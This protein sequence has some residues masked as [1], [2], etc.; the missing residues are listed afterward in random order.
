MV[1]IKP[2]ETDPIIP[3]SLSKPAAQLAFIPP[4]GPKCSKEGLPGTPVLNCSTC[5]FSCYKKRDL[6]V[7]L[8][9]HQIE[10]GIS[11]KC[12]VCPFSA[13]EQHEFD[14]HKKSHSPVRPF[15]CAYCDYSQYLRAKV[16][17]HCKAMHQEE[18]VQVLDNGQFEIVDVKATRVIKS[19]KISIKD[20]LLMT[21]FELETLL[22]NN[23]G[24][25]FN[26]NFI[27]DNYLYR[28]EI[29]TDASNNDDDADSTNT[30]EYSANDEQPMEE[31]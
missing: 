5:S 27:L 25:R 12:S 21:Q 14:E 29:C 9:D 18:P 16:K 13:V 26:C 7:H 19:P 8:N 20:V 28:I 11:M 17:K 2:L 23:H 3:Q 6:L 24:S 10:N 15:K 1:E 31:Q 4:P 30:E 22:K